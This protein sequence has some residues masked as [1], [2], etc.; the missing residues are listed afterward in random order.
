MN[1]PGTTSCIPTQLV[2]LISRGA[3]AA[4]GFCRVAGSEATFLTFL[5]GCREHSSSGLGSCG[6]GLIGREPT[7]CELRVDI[8]ELTAEHRDGSLAFVHS[9]P[10]SPYEGPKKSGQYRHNQ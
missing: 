1:V 3:N 7:L 9:L 10:S 6:G 2:P 8:R 5:I 4:G